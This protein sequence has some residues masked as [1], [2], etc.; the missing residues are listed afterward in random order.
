MLEALLV[1]GPDNTILLNL[2]SPSD[3]ALESG[4]WRAAHPPRSCS[5]HPLCTA[6]VV[7]EDAPEVAKDLP[8]KS[9]GQA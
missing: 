8:K 5:Q 1:P 4:R 2:L 9:G 7:F 3:G 6:R